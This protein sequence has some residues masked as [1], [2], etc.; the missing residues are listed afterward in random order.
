MTR[1]LAFFHL[2]SP[3]SLKRAVAVGLTALATL[4]RPFLAAK[5]I[6]TP[7]DEQMTALAGLVALYV[8]QS[9]VKSTVEAHAAGKVA[10]AQ[11]VTSAQADAV[12]DRA[13]AEAKVLNPMPTPVAP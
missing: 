4:V 13:I 11:V 8:L 3:D 9:G 1:L 12:L 6:P 10:A 7:D 2:D 5:G